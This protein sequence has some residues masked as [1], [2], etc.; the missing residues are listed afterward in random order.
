LIGWLGT[1]STG[2]DT[3]LTFFLET[4][5]SSPHNNSESRRT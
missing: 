4:C 3:P 1:A 2:S 5:R